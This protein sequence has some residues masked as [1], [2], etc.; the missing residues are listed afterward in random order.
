MSLFPRCL[1]ELC[2]KHD[3]TCSAAFVDCCVAAPYCC[4]VSYQLVSVTG[5]M[6][7]A[8]S[9]I[10]AREGTNVCFKLILNN[11]VS[12]YIVYT[13]KV[14]MYLKINTDVWLQP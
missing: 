10:S 8:A 5:W 4:M 11:P 1:S 3:D 7:R 14:I 13:S 12:A 2:V 9:S 6:C